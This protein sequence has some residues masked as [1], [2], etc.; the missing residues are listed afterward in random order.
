MQTSTQA[1]PA[2]SIFKFQLGQELV[3]SCSNEYGE[4]I[5]RS[6]SLYSDP[7]YLVRYRAN[8]DRATEAWWSQSAL[9]AA[10]DDAPTATNAPASPAIAD[11]KHPLKIGSL[12]PDQ[13]G[14]FAGLARGD[15]LSQDYFLVLST[16]QTQP[17]DWRAAHRWAMQLGAEGHSDW[18]TPTRGELQLMRA[19]GLHDAMMMGKTWTSEALHGLPG[20]AWAHFVGNSERAGFETLEST[21]L[22]LNAVAVRRLRLQA[23]SSAA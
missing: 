21:D 7:Q 2:A 17:M 4:C 10:D 22:K 13:G 8:D 12:W 3:I 1:T 11:A 14:L 20:T 19:S 16:R 15:G 9:A 18:V 5:A 23:H 6:E